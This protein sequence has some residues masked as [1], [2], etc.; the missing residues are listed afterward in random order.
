[1][2]GEYEMDISTNVDVITLLMAYVIASVPLLI[3]SGIIYAIF[4]ICERKQEK[5]NREAEAKAKE[6][7]YKR[8]VEMAQIGIRITNEPRKKSKSEPVR[9]VGGVFSDMVD[10]WK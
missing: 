7:Q 9:K 3:F 6:R 2:K 4:V 5:R 10:V 1:M 8:D